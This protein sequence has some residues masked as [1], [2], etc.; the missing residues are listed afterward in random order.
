MKSP[1]PPNVP[2]HALALVL[3]VVSRLATLPVIGPA[4]RA[5]GWAGSNLL[6]R[7]SPSVPHDLRTNFVRDDRS[8]VFWSSFVITVFFALVIHVVLTAL[9]GTFIGPNGC[10]DYWQIARIY[11]ACDWWNIALYALV[12]PIYVGAACCLILTAVR[13]WHSVRS[14]TCRIAEEPAEGRDGHRFPIFLVVTLTAVAF[15][16]FNYISDLKRATYKIRGEQRI[17]G[18]YWF[19]DITSDGQKVL[20]DVGAYYLLL[21]AVL[22]FIT[23]CA[24]FCLIS[25]S[26]EIVRIGSRIR[27]CDLRDTLTFQQLRDEL[28]AYSDIY[29]LG[30]ILI[31]TYIANIY[32][33][34]KSP[35]GHVQNIEFAAI[36]AI[37]VGSALIAGPRY[38]L[39]LRWYE[40]AVETRRARQASGQETGTDETDKLYEEIVPARHRLLLWAVDGLVIA[41]FATYWL[42]ERWGLDPSWLLDLGQLIERLHGN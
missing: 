8:Y 23:V 42:K 40:L 37:L 34:A 2:A 18:L 38:Y 32:I 5:L 31:A 14:F 6:F 36:A 16:I 13:N 27:D 17:D 41:G 4:I 26:I 28:R 1:T 25:V 19:M 21:N 7:V 30:K 15:F 24:L 11:F 33:W 12:V 3:G 9:Q 29:V 10:A 20:N 22:L 35:A 39:E